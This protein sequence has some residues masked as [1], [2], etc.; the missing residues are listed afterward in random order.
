MTSLLPALWA[1]AGVL[2][3]GG[4]AKL[5]SPGSTRQALAAAGIR[6]PA[7]AVRAVGAAEVALAAACVAFPGRST[8]AALA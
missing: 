6:A 4:L 5:R 7:P 1:A 2:A 8:A 3:I